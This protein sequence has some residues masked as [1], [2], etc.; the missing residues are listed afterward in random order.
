MCSPI[1]LL[2]NVRSISWLG[3]IFPGGVL[4]TAL[5]LV[6]YSKPRADVKLPAAHLRRKKRVIARDVPQP[7][8][9]KAYYVPSIFAGQYDTR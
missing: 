2:P 6:R 5:V 7:T 4:T 1:V 8:A 3:A 9:R